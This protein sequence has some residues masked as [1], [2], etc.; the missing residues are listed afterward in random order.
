MLRKE[1]N[2]LHRDPVTLGLLIAI[3][4]IQLIIFGY[5]VNTDVKHVATAVVDYSHT[6][7][8]RDLLSAFENSQYFDMVRYVDSPRDLIGL[9]DGGEVKAGFVIPPDYGTRLLAGDAAPVQ[10]LLDGSDASSATQILALAS[11]IAQT[12]AF[13]LMARRVSNHGFTI[14]PAL[15]FRP[16]VLYNPELRSAVFFVPGLLGVILQMIAVLFTSFAIVREKE[17]GTIEQLLVS[18][19][20]P[21]ELVV[22]K[23]LPYA[24]IAFFDTVLVFIAASLLFHVPFRG[25]VGLLLW[26]T[27]PFLVASLGLGLL[28]STLA[29]NQAQALHL[30][31][32]FIMPSFILSGFVFPID[33][34]PSVIQWVSR[35][36]PLTYYLMILR[37]ILIRGVG[38]RYL[39][40]ALWP[41]LTF[42]VLLVL[43]SAS[44][45]KKRLQ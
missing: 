35:F 12:M 41:L 42:A 26:L 9:I 43:L 20:R 39:W 13:R 29:Q 14:E 31:F 38:M 28:I 8:S 40:N 19:I 32:L 15:D 25:N 1:L 3:P 21:L 34:M 6:Q 37:G 36:I 18:P 11:T 17:R 10:L 27:L 33:T 45:F 16:R 23:L 44:R 24:S 7:Q 22:G 4:V 2:Q 5:A 30:G